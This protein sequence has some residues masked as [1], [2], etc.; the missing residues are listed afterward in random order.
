MGITGQA[1]A[2]NILHLL[3]KFNLDPRLL[4]WQGYDGAGNM[5]VKT[6]GAAAIITAQYPLALYVHCASHQLNLVVVRS[7]EVTSIRNMMGTSKKLH[8][9]FQ[10]YPK[11]QQQ[12]ESAIEITHRESRQRKIKDLSR[13]RWVQRL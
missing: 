12:I 10:A 7:A 6:W 11:H 9:F 5:A 3:Q 2:E 8:D 13:T 1:V 4:H